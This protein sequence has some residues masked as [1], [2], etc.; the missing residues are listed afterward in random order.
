MNST[1]SRY[2][3]KRGLGQSPSGVRGRAPR[4]ENFDFGAPNHT[5]KQQK[6]R[7]YVQLPATH[8]CTQLC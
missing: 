4:S 7:L 3:K 5:M 1:F 8:I 2:R 6:P